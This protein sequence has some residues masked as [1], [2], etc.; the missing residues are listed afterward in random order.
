MLREWCAQCSRCAYVVPVYE[1]KSVV[2]RDVMP[3]S[4]AELLA[5][6]ERYYAR[7]CG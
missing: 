5:M 1:I 6:V 2:G 7:R 4:K 3:S